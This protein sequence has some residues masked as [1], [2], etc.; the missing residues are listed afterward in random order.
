MR[1]KLFIKYWLLIWALTPTLKGQSQDHLSVASVSTEVAILNAAAPIITE[2]SSTPF[3]SDF[4]SKLIHPKAIAFI[5]DYQ[6]ENEKH[7]NRL[8]LNHL[9]A[10]KKIES[11]LEKHGIPKE[12][13]YLAIIESELKSSAR[14]HAG[15]VG[16]WQLMPVTA[17]DYGLVVNKR[18][19][20]RMDLIKSTHAAAK[21]IKN[22]HRKFNDWLLVVAAFN[23]G[24]GRVSRAMAAGHSDNYWEIEQY[25]PRESRGHVRRYIATHYILEGTGGVTTATSDLVTGLEKSIAF[26]TT[27]LKLNRIQITGKFHSHIVSKMVGMDISLFQFLNPG[28]DGKVS[29]DNY[30]LCLPEEHMELFN[31]NRA[32]ILEAS[33]QYFLI[34]LN[35][36][37]NI[38]DEQKY[39]FS[40]REKINAGSNRP[41]SYNRLH[42]KLFPLT[43]F[44]YS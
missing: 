11:I 32:A 3:A 25:L 20:D 35:F 18:R 28:F 1:K 13:K 43:Y 9:P 6:V 23:S 7:L 33:V 19:D 4:Y 44:K 29:I 12:L 27:L 10:I 39:A 37:M 21:Y 5:K 22:L 8:K 2:K 24:E 15:A 14:S 16:P 36:D 42:R 26:D 17:R 40:V 30:T 38:T 31:K 41:N 34:G